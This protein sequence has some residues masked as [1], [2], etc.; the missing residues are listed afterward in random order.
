MRISKKA[1]HKDQ[2]VR[3]LQTKLQNDHDKFVS[4]QTIRQ[5]VNAYSELILEYVVDG[6]TFGIEKVGTIYNRVI[7]AKDMY[8]NLTKV[9]HHLPVRYSPGFKFNRTLRDSVKYKDVKPEDEQ[10]LMEFM[11]KKE[12]K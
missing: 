8:N 4:L 6:N 10:E 1:V 12:E 2:I 3:D 7:P 9:V 5:L 11:N